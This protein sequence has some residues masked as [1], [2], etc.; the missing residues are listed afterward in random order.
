MLRMWGEPDSNR[1]PDGSPNPAPR[2]PTVIVACSDY[3]R[4]VRRSVT[5]SDRDG[6]PCQCTRQCN[7][8]HDED[9]IRASRSIVALLCAGVTV[10]YIAAVV[11]GDACPR[12]S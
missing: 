2:C 10:W 8:H 1:Q 12:I 7:H 6:P 4:P 11:I 3:R 9:R 5:M